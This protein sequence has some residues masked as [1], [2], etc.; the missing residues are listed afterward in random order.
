[1]RS[2]LLI[3]ALSLMVIGS[4]SAA[5]FYEPFNY[6][7]G[8]LA[9]S[10]PASGGNTNPTAPSSVTVNSTTFN[11]TNVWTTSATG[12]NSATVIDGDLTYTNLPTTSTAHMAQLAAAA[13]NP[14][15]VAIGDYAEGST[16]WFSML[17]QVPTGVTSFG[18]SS[19]TGSFLA[20]FQYN[21][22]TI[23]AATTMTDGAAGAGG[24]LT[25]RN[26]GSSTSGYN[27]G[28][29][30]RD[31]TAGTSRVFNT[32]SLSAGT[33]YLVV[34]NFAVNAGD[35][36]DIAKLWINPDPTASDP[37][38]PG[39]TSDNSV[40]HDAHDYFYNN[41]TGALLD[42]SI[43][44]F[45]LRSNGVEPSNINLDEIRIG[46]SYADVVGAAAVP[47]PALCGAMA[48]FGA[49]LLARRRR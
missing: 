43:R 16:I 4:A 11:N 31:I 8:P 27:L 19:T 33:T 12:G 34:G 46:S 45:M 25:I 10:T 22:T 26:S 5:T 32:T 13:K 41:S 21:P 38:T 18:S 47:E 9:T 42:T 15:R 2:C 36:N 35:F 23:S 30:Y 39:A 20:G 17:L 37:G 49:G 6:S 3:N 40:I 7:N 44:S 29:G 28:I 24:V 14:D 1:M 48:I